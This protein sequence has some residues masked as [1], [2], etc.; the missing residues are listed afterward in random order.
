MIL[1]WVTD[2]WLIW[3]GNI[4]CFFWFASVSHTEVILVFKF[5]MVTD[6]QDSWAPHLRFHSPLSEHR[7]IFHASLVYLLTPWRAS[8]ASLGSALVGV[9]EGFWQVCLAWVQAALKVPT[10][11]RMW[12]V[13]FWFSSFPPFFHVWTF[14]CHYRRL[15]SLIVYL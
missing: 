2:S 14:F 10:K 5:K 11:W 6:N 8:L 15:F 13:S 9:S 3:C 12:C 7:Q 1:G 4:N